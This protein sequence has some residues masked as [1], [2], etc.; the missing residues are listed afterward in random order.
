MKQ[1]PWKIKWTT[2]AKVAIKFMPVN[3][4]ILDL[5][6]GQEE[7]FN[8]LDG[9]CEYLSLD[10]E[11][12]G[13]NTIKFDFNSGKEYPE[14][15]ERQFILCLGTIEYVND[16]FYFLKQTRK[17][18]QRLIITYRKFS[19]GGMMRKNNLRFKDVE[20]MLRRAGWSVLA[21][22]TITKEDGTTT[23]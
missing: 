16:P 3:P 17:Y 8:L 6:G 12:W 2:R 7:V 19:N 23:G 11:A 20:R 4:S 10:L 1:Y 21:T 14:L 18:S 22:K 13:P 9:K 5:G 15:K